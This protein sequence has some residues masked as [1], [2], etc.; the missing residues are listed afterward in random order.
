[1]KPWPNLLEPIPIQ[2]RDSVSR[3]VGIYSASRRWLRILR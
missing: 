2:H 1:M 3:H